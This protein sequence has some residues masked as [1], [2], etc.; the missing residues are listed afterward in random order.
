MRERATARPRVLV[1]G[2][3]LQHVRKARELGL[4]VVLAQF[5]DEYDSSHWPYVDQALLLD[6]GDIDRLLPLVQGVA[7]GVPVPGC[8]VAVR[9]RAA[10]GGADQRGARPRRRVRRHRGAAAGQVADAPAPGHEGH[11]PGGLRGRPYRAGP[12]G[13]RPGERAPDHRQADPRVGQPGGVLHPRPSRRGCRRRT[14]PISRRQAVGRRRPRVCRFLPRVPHG[15]VPGRPGDQRGDPDLRRPARGRRGDRQG[16]RRR[17]LRRDRTLAAQR[18]LG[19]DAARGDP[20]GDGLPGR[21]G[22]A[23]RSRA[24]RGQADL[25][26]PADRRVAQPHRR[27]PDQRAGRDRLRRRHGALRA[28]RQVR[29]GGAADRVA[30]ASRRCGHPRHHTGARPGRGSDRRRRRTRGPGVRRPP[31]GVGAGRRGATADLERGQGRSRHRPRRHRRRG[32]RPQQRLGSGDPRA[33]R[34]VA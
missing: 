17:R 5:P 31:A 10:A 33:H 23:Q 14:V 27:W 15:G 2:G 26:R 25:A 4:D 32:D 13:V 3:K 16:D 11:Q 20:V 1:I 24:H 29:P 8:R 18:L 12:A 30:R 28:G 19:R 21:G 22:A 6:Y 34:A 7:Q 9:A